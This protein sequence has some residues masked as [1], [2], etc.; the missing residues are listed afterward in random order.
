MISN[1]HRPAQGA[2]PAALQSVTG[3][4]WRASRSGSGGGALNGSGRSGFRENAGDA[5]A[6]LIVRDKCRASPDGSGGRPGRSELEPRHERLEEQLEHEH[7]K[8]RS[9]APVSTA[10]EGNVAV[11]GRRSGHESFGTKGRGL[12]I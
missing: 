6:A 12:W 5:H 2:L 7:C 10:A 1:G 4:G 3:R 11:A 9:D 8:R